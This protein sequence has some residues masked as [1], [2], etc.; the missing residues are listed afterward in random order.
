MLVGTIARV[1]EKEIDRG[2]QDGKKNCVRG[3]VAGVSDWA[4]TGELDRS[5]GAR[6]LNIRGEKRPP[7]RL[8]VLV[9]LRTY[10]LVC[11]R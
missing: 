6:Q 9:L 7:T 10:F 5:G 3:D 11:N 8:I 2:V 4:T 1:S